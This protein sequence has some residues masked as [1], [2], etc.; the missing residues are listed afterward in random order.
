[1]GI[2]ENKKAMRRIV[3]EVLNNKDLSVIPELISPDFYMEAVFGTF[4]GPDGFKQACEIR[5]AAFPDVHYTIEGM[6]GEGD[7]LATQLTISGTFL[8]KF[9]DIEPTGRQFTVPEA[10]ISQYKDGKELLPTSYT[11]MLS[12]FLQIGATPPNPS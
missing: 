9:G 12:F 2:E 6:I 1:M 4:R 8:G 11:N 10:V 7:M 5:N 3:E